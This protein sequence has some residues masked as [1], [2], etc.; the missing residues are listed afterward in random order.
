VTFFDVKMPDGTVSYDNCG[1]PYC[2]P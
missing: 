1:P 2:V